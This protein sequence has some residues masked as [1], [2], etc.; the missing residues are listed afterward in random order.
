MF[1]LD[2]NTVIHLFKGAGRVGERLLGTPPQQV[3][4]PSLV[5]YEFEVGILKSIDPVKRRQQFSALLAQVRVLPFTQVEAERAAQI[6][7]ALEAKG[8]GIGPLDTLIA[9]VAIASQ[10]T[11][12]TRNVREFS[13]AE[14][15][16]VVNWYD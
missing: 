8:E 6:R 2:T 4:I 5:V 12:V 14:G 10:A 3:T 11:L 1:A 16:K 15:L 9:G 13:R 7:T